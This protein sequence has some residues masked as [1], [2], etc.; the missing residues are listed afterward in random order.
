MFGLLLLAITVHTD[1]EAGS[2]G[3]VERVS[4]THLRCSVAGESDQD[5]RNRQANWYY[6]RLENVRGRDLT[7]DLVDLVGEYNYRPGA[8]SVTKDTHPFYSYDNKDWT[9]FDRI[10]WDDKAIRLRVRLKPA[11]DRVWIAHVPPYTTRHLARLLESIGKHPHLNRGVVGKT[12]EGRDMLL[13]TVT[14]PAVPDKRKKV[15]WLMLRQHAWETGTSWV[16]EGALRFLV[17]EDPRA[18]RIRSETVF[19]IFPMADPDGVARGGVRFNQYGYDLNRNWDCAEPGRMPEISA[20]RKA[21]LDWV[22][23]G[24]R[25]D[26]FLAMHNTETGEYLSAAPAD[27]PAFRAVR[28]RFHSALVEMTTF[29]PT[30]NA[31]ASGARARP[32]QPAQ[33]CRMSVGE[34]LY[35]ARQ[36]PAVMSEQMVARSPRLGR[37]P[38]IQDRIDFGAGLVRAMATAVGVERVN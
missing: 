11:Q 38:T 10:E 9:P 33:A 13:L 5:R 20:Q 2:L 6:F 26:L 36:I 18:V 22:D 21:I 16:G 8:H 27:N 35:H 19:K 14:N 15:V 17:S 23:S 37:F 32:A 1:F 34:Y 29:S 12:P 3:K 25:I 7:I 30:Q 4:E 24:K 28:D 31:S